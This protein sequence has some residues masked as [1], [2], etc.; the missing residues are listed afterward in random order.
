MTQRDADDYYS[1]ANT[2]RRSQAALQAWR[3]RRREGSK[4]AKKKMRSK[5][6]LKAWATR[7]ANEL[8]PRK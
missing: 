4:W 8:G 1:Q 7:R 6:A 5:A 3:S 2:E